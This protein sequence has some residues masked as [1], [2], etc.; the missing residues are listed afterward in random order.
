MRTSRPANGGYFG[1]PEACRIVGITYRR[2]DHWARTGLVTPSLRSVQGPGTPR[3]YSFADLV[4]L[5]TIKELLAAGVARADNGNG[6]TYR[7]SVGGRQ[8]RPKQP[9]PYLLF[10]CYWSAWSA[11]SI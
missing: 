1:G 4:E 2:L 7:W 10:A 5:R 6:P 3:R 8:V 11:C 9:P